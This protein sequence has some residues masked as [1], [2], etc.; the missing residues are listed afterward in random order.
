MKNKLT[1]LNNHL[2]AELE[3]LSDEDLKDGALQQE[4]TRANAIQGI[5]KEII[6]NAHLVLKAKIAIN[7]KTLV[8]AP[9]MLGIEGRSSVAS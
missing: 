8:D 9:E 5:A 3:R 7:E 4:V 6:S 1:D 2:F